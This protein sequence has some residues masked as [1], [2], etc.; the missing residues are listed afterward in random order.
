MDA[1]MFQEPRRRMIRLPDGE[2]AALDFGDEKRPV[3]VVFLH[4]T[5]FNAMTYRSILAPLSPGLRILAVDQRGHGSSR[6]PA[7]PAALRSWKPFRDDLLA[8]LSTLGGPPPV[9]SGHS[10][11]GTV[12]LLAAAA[13]PEATSGLVLFDPVVLDRWR[14]LLANLPWNAGS[15]RRTPLAMGAAK[16]RA[17]F[18]NPSAAFNAYIGRG[19]FKTWTKVMLA[20][21]IAGGLKPRSDGKVE[22]ACTP[23]MESAVFAS[24]KHDAWAAAA[25][26]RAP[27]QIYRAEQGSTCRIGDGAGF[28]GRNPRASLVTV[29]AASHFL[30]MERPD[31]VRDALLDAAV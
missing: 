21:Y 29:A 20:D 4:A 30:P 18:D 10:M 1:A 14:T 24:H 12:A 28:F 26:V 17:V 15:M 23:A 16:R 11:G 27:I 6:L 8:L 2:M 19:A 9:L 3:D 22:L 13:R 25:K 31:L 5:G 7:D